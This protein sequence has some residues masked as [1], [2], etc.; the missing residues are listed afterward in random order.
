MAIRQQTTQPAPL[1]VLAS[2][3]CGSRYADILLQILEARCAAC[4]G[5]VREKASGA[6]GEGFRFSIPLRQKPVA[7]FEF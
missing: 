3:D 5:G 6:H 1:A 2:K 7:S 4:G